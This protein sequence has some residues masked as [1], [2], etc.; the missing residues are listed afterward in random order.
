M[1]MDCEEG[2]GKRDKVGKILLRV[3]KTSSALLCMLGVPAS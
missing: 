2:Y 3:T 1:R